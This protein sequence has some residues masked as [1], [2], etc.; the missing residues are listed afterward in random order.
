[1]VTEAEA[2]RGVTGSLQRGR[3]A[4]EEQRSTF[5]T[6]AEVQARSLLAGMV[7][8][9]IAV[10]GFLSW[11]SQS[12]YFTTG[13]DIGIHDQA[14]WLAAHGHSTFDTVRGLGYFG[15]NVNLISMVLVPFYW[16]GAGPHFLIVVNTL[17]LGLG[18]IPLWLIARDRL[19][20]PLLALIPA[21]CYL[22]YPTTGYLNWWGFHPDT[23]AIT[24][25]FFAW[26]FALRGRWA[27]YALCV[28]VAMS[29]KEDMALSVLAMGL[30]LAF[31]SGFRRNA[32]ANTDVVSRTLHRHAARS[33]PGRLAQR[34]GEDGGAGRLARALSTSDGRRQAGL[35][36]A[37]VAVA[38]FEICTKVILPM[39]NFGLPPFYSNYFWSLGRTPPQVIGN[40]V[41]HP[42]RVAKL[43]TLP[44]RKTYYVQMFAPVGFLIVLAL[45]A[46]LVGLPQFGINVVD[47]GELGATITSQYSTL[48]TVGVFLAT[49][50]ALSF[51]HRRAPAL[52][53]AACV[54]LIFSTAAST[55]AWGIT[56]I[57]V[58]FH[59]W[60][61]ARNR[62]G[63][64]IAAALELLP[65]SAGVAVTYN[66]TPQVTHRVF[67]YEFPNPWINVNWLSTR[68][69]ERPATVSWIV[70][71]TDLLNT[72]SQQLFNQLTGPKGNFRV[73]YASNGIVAARRG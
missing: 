7:G 57:G 21:A 40:T 22:L 8:L 27:W 69:A 12:Q 19:E 47:Q 35:V 68:V 46:L 15:E 20:S 41:L 39:N 66:L 51:I 38:W 24:P 67:A 23:L 26:W 2:V 48:V 4:A 5:M 34:R 52:L 49:V 54:L 6:D 14:I 65:S 44:T 3:A 16:L 17:G 9:Y 70:V 28:V 42:S 25:L 53:W 56:P 18:A 73:V 63:V 13:F 59:T 72:P 31:W 1:V 10:F 45:P 37:V 60:W 62:R 64:E 11:R 30:V 43:A 29:C 61:P 71:E 36:S 33:T 58:R 50:E 55:V 32:D